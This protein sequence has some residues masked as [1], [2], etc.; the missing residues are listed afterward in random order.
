MLT[1]P[2]LS[3]P[4]PESI[5]AK[6]KGRDMRPVTET[7]LSDLIRGANA[8][9]SVRGGGTRGAVAVGDAVQTGGLTGV[10]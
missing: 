7:E 2:G 4:D 8:P 3:A 10:E 5:S 6:M 1:L 9:L